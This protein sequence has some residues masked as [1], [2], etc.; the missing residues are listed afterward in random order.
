L[1]SVGE[2]WAKVDGAGTR[3]IPTTTPKAL[4]KATAM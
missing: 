4:I 3:I 2:D 1:R